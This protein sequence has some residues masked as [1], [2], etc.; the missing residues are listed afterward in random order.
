MEEMSDRVIDVAGHM[1]KYAAP[2]TIYVPREV[3]EKSKAHEGF[4]P[5]NANVDGYEVYTWKAPTADPT[6]TVLRGKVVV[7]GIVT[8]PRARAQAQPEADKS[9]SN[10]G[11]LSDLSSPGAGGSLSDLVNP[12]TTYQSL[13]RETAPISEK[14]GSGGQVVMASDKTMLRPPPN[15]LG[16]YELKRE[17]GRGAMG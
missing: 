9:A 15:R 8:N 13:I 4:K 5:A 2:D 16:K 1:Q 17:L 12:S 3:L 10:L 7:D 14:T 6:A 11:S